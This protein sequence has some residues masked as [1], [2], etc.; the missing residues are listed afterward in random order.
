[1]REDRRGFGIWAFPHLAALTIAGLFATGCASDSGR[2]GVASEVPAG[3][4]FSYD[5]ESVW[6]RSPDVGPF[7][8]WTTQPQSYVSGT[9]AIQVTLTNFAEDEDRSPEDLI[10]VASRVGSRDFVDVRL[11]DVEARVYVS[12]NKSGVGLRDPSRPL[13]PAG[14]VFIV[15]SGVTSREVADA[16][17]VGLSGLHY[18]EQVAFD[19]E[20]DEILDQVEQAVDAARSL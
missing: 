1:M 12:G 5:G 17:V 11:C 13:S 18:A 6:S 7:S 16:L 15:Q 9:A 20:S 14:V 4:S 2:A 10:G 19:C 3:W 8:A